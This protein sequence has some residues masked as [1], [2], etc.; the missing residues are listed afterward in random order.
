M[1]LAALLSAHN[2]WLFTL[3]LLVSLAFC[4]ASM[5]VMSSRP[6][7]RTPSA[8]IRVARAGALL[9]GAVWLVFI[10]CWKGFFPFVD[11]PMPTP[12]LASSLL[13]A[14]AGA[15]VA[16]AISVYGHPGIRNATLAG[17]ILAASASCMLFVIMSVIAAPLALG[18]DLIEVLLSMIGCTLL[19][20]AGLHGIRQAPTRRKMLLPAALVATAIPVLNIASFSSILPF[21]EWEIASATPGA[22]ALQP[23]TIVF[24]SEFAAVIALTRAGAAVDR[25][26][27]VRTQRE[28]D[29][30]R[31]LTDST[32]EGLLVHRAG[33][34]IDANAAFCRMVGLPLDAIKD[35][36]ISDFAT[37]FP[38]L[39]SHRPMETELLVASADAIPVEM[40]S[41]EI[42]LGD[43]QVEVTAVRDIRERRAAEQ[44]ARDRQRVTALQHE[45]EEARE[46][47]HIA[48]EASRAKSAFLAMMSHEIRTPMNGVLGLATVLLDDALIDEQREVVRAI[49]SSGNSLLRIL[50]DILDFSRLDTGRMAFELAPFSPG[51]LTQQTLSVHEPVAL[52]KGLRL[53][54]TQAPDLP[55]HLI[56]DAGR[57]GQVLHNLVSNALKFTRA[58]TVTVH[59]RCLEQAGDTAVI[60]WTVSDTG[61]GIPPEKL[62]SLFNAF[63]QAD[64]SIAR[65]F[66]GSGLGLAISKQLVDQMGGTITVSSTPDAGSTFTVRLP[67]KLAAEQR[68]PRPGVVPDDLLASRLK[69]LERPLRVLLA[70]DN[71]T[72][73]FVF[74]RLL[75]GA[76]VAVDVANNGLEAVRLA[77]Q[78]AYDLI[79]MDMSMPEMD[80][81]EATR[82][83]RRGAGP[84]RQVPIIALTANAFPEDIAA[85]HAAGMTDFVSKPVSKQAL[86]D[87]FLRAMPPGEIARQASEAA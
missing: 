40:L 66:G 18:Y 27:A 48:E 2:F 50:N 57:I 12:E 55:E 37:A 83:I 19:V 69:E 65:R 16:V 56:G 63:V 74:I 85:C 28:N 64:S 25:Q 17:S 33:R 3:A 71:T 35:R 39:P 41:G 70:E 10:L 9:G 4:G 53:Y 1:S 21:T 47:Q 68:P 84:C 81:L 61:I 45:T 82:L 31:Q 38:D 22:L 49:H 52:E 6:A 51:T 77:E 58:G 86:V 62:G 76:A 44:S 46:R 32:F 36:P 72:N 54:V 15:T 80:G 8:M 20:S 13:L 67:L 23:L 78:N 30:L 42:N 59:S 73:Q 11:A 24:L 29:R 14:I 43:G 87:A 7:G 75:R 34:V 60:V 5:Y 26:T 79:C